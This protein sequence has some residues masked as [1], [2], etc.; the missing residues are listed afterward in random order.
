MGGCIGGV[1]NESSVC[2]FRNESKV[3]S[4]DLRKEESVLQMDVSKHVFSSRR[5][6]MLT[7][8]I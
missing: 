6:A 5:F 3:G 7:S 4:K 8:F 2:G 1:R